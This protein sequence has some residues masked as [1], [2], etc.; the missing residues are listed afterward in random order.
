MWQFKEVGTRQF[1]PNDT[2]PFDKRKEKIEKLLAGK[3][4]NYIHEAKGQVVYNEKQLE[5]AKEKA[6][7]QGWEG[8]IA[9]AIK[10]LWQGGD[11]KS[12]TKLKQELT[13]DLAIIGY[14]R[15]AK[16]L[17]VLLGYKDNGRFVSLCGCGS[18]FKFNEKLK[19][20]ALLE[21]QRLPDNQQHDKSNILVKPKYVIEVSYQELINRNGR[22][23]LRHP[24]FKRIRDDKT[25]NDTS[26]L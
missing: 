8:I 18:G 3:T 17:S 9:K 23:A 2:T 21:T 24:V 16:H 13:A 6:L 12:W 15:K 7:K 25:I 4:F 20:K 10:G 19:L 22:K 5:Q 11:I 14:S 1:Y 26:L